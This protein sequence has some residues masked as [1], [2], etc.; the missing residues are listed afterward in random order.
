[1]SQ[2]TVNSSWGV[3][4]SGSLFTDKD[5]L[6]WVFLLPVVEVKFKPD[7]DVLTYILRDI[8]VF[9]PNTVNISGNDNSTNTKMLPRQ[10][11][12]DIA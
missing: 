7:T 9:R 6:H 2:A 10:N 3:R 11:V 8:Q 12:E 1:M 5:K 4:G